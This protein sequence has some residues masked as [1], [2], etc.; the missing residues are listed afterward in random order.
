[1]SEP[2]T[3]IIAHE[4]DGTLRRAFYTWKRA[5][6]WRDSVNGRYVLTEVLVEE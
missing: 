4:K 5:R 6:E 1:M 2:D 3:V